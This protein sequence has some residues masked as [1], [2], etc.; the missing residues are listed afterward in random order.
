MTARTNPHRRRVA[1]RARRLAAADTAQRHAPLHADQ[2]DFLDAYQPLKISADAWIRVREPVRAFMS[3]TGGFLT[4]LPTFRNHLTHVTHFAVWLDTQG[5]P[6][7]PHT[8]TNL[9]LID[10]FTRVGQAGTSKNGADRRSRL[11]WLAAAV[12]PDIQLP[13]RGYTIP[14]PPIKPPYT[15]PEV[16]A[17]VRVAGIQPTAEMTR[18][19]SAVVGLGLGAGCD[20]TDLKAMRAD[21]V[22]DS[23]DDGIVVTIRSRGGQRRVAVLRPYEDLVRRSVTGLNPGQL[24]L[25]Q[26]EDRANVS[27]PILS[28]AKLYGDVPRI[29]PGRLRTTWLASLMRR[30][31]PLQVILHAAGLTS[32]RTLTDL[33][34]HL[35]GADATTLRDQVTA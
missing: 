34:P 27:T 20:G 26:K 31:V 18:Q 9:T 10:E 5:Q 11:R 1:S 23:G 15:D 14:R 33:L 2:Q 24:L 6:V 22:E 30:P 19:L 3:R 28:R 32:A 13:T 17:I 35:S 25:G 8:L 29:E 16:S 7:T 12:N 21:D 4:G